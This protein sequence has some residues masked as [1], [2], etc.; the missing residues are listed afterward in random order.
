MKKMKCCECLPRPLKFLVFQFSRF[1]WKL[2]F[3]M[4]VSAARRVV[5]TATV[6]ALAFAPWHYNVK[7]IWL[8]SNCDMDSFTYHFCS[9][10]QFCSKTSCILWMKFVR[11]TK[12]KIIHLWSQWQKIKWTVAK[13]KLLFA[14]VQYHVMLL[15][16]LDYCLN[17]LIL[18]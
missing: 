8:L 18:I 16:A 2:S 9:S 11:L 7:Q 10:K 15:A 12:Y 5:V 1:F 17:L 14:L 6:P 13:W 3:G 4:P